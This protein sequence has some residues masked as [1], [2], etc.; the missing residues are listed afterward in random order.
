MAKQKRDEDAREA[1]DALNSKRWA[2]SPGS[3]RAARLEALDE[4]AR[5]LAAGAAVYGE[6]VDGVYREGLPT[7]EA[8]AFAVGEGHDPQMSA[9]A[10]A[11]ANGDLSGL[12]GLGYEVVQ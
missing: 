5:L 8:V 9:V 3:I 2:G 12:K 7:P 4:L 10:S 6:I 11:L 1:L